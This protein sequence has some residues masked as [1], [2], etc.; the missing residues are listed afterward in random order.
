MNR[1]TLIQ[2]GAAALALGALGVGAFV[3]RRRGQDARMSEAI[4]EAWPELGEGIFWLKPNLDDARMVVP[5]RPHSKEESRVGGF[6]RTRTFH[7]STNSLRLRNGPLGAKSGKRILCMGD[8]VTFGW[9]VPDDQSYPVQ[10]ERELR[11]RGHDVEVLN[12]GVPAQSIFGMKR[13]VEMQAAALD[14]DAVLWTRRPQLNLP[15]PIGDYVRELRHAQNAL[16]NA[17][18]GV[19]LTPVSRFDPYGVAHYADEEK[20]LRRKLTVPLV[21]LSPV[22]FRAQT[23]GVVCEGLDQLTMKHWDGRVIEQAPRPEFDLPPSFYA[24]FEADHDLK[25]HLFFDSGHPDAEGFTLFAR[26]VADLVEDN[27]WLG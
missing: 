14:V 18:F 23:K 20:E 11:A 1:R 17:K 21:E 19:V 15:S 8:S 4:T 6:G 2:G 27:G 25:E 16:P 10:L 22:F 7:V 3:Q 13:F 12:A 26:T 9:G 24:A 5:D